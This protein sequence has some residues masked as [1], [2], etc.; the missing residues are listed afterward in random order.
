M[1]DILQTILEPSQVLSFMSNFFNCVFL[2]SEQFNK[3]S[4]EICFVTETNTIKET[5]T[6][7]G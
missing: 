4:N 1:K 5:K 7:T 2:K 3:M 6:V